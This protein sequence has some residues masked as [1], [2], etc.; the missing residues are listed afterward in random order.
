MPLKPGSSQSTI[1]QNI[2]EM[3]ASGHPQN[4]A[5]AASLSNSRRHPNALG[6]AV[7]PQSLA[8]PGADAG[9]GSLPHFEDGGMPNT[10][11]FIRNAAREIYHPGGL[12]KSTTA[13]RTDRLPMSVATNSYVMPADVVS[14]LGQGNTMAGA[15]TLEAAL[16]I[17]PHGTAL[18]RGHQRGSSLPRAPHAPRYAAGGSPDR[19]SILAAGGEYIVHADDVLRL[20]GGDARKGHRILD[21]FV[22]R[23]R[24]HTAKTLRKLPKPK[25]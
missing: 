13:G 16:R 22:E 24:S 17:G 21:Q 25:K 9:L 6:G 10:P 1:S 5:V 20:G 3:V 7:A 15:H 8:G 11:W 4:Q 12:I 2:R 14:G 18:P 19:T 23:I